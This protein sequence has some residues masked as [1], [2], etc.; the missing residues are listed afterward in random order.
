MTDRANPQI[1][2][3]FG[4]AF[5]GGDFFVLDDPTK[6]VLDGVDYTLAGDVGTDIAADGFDIQIRRGRERNLDEFVPGSCTVRLH[7]LDRT[8]DGLY[9]SSPY[10]SGLVPGKRVT[11]RVWDQTIFD[12]TIED[13]N[14]EWS[15][16]NSTAELFAIDALGAL[17]VCEFDAWT[18]SASQTA[19]D[20]LDE[21][22]S[23]PEVNFSVA[24]D[25]DSGISVLQA[26][27][28][29][30]GTNVLARCQLVAASDSGRLFV[31]RDGILTFHD[32]HH[33]LSETPETTFAPDGTGHPY[34]AASTVNGADLLYNRATVDRVGGTLQSAEDATSR[35]NYGPRSLPSSRTTGLLLDSDAEALDMAQ[36]LVN[37]YAEPIDRMSSLSVIV[38]VLDTE[39]DRA[40]V[41][42]LDVGDLVS[43]VWR[44]FELGFSSAQPFVVE[45]VEHHI[46]VSGVHTLALKLTTTPGYS[47]FLLDDPIYGV[48]DGF[49]STLAF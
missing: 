17:G 40:E 41:T 45:G 18:T 15:V 48:L 6:G 21:M 29:E 24:R 1:T 19:G 9:A 12:G 27:T 44:P 36:H 13:W 16:D 33:L 7:N 20:R 10:F 22:L 46:D 30:H 35:G 39:I 34:H 4:A 49:T 31:T 5:D 42:R 47:V 38:N 43:V 26:D 3:Y 2:V 28:I 23:R 8:Y 32:R 37:F 25:F 14:L 11:V